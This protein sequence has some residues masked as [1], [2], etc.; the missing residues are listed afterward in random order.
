MKANMLDGLYPDNPTKEALTLL[1]DHYAAL[2]TELDRLDPP[3]G[4]ATWHDRNIDLWELDA[5]IAILRA[6]GLSLEEA[7]RALVPDDQDPWADLDQER[8]LAIIACPDFGEFFRP[9]PSATP[10]TTPTR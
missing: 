2:A 5:E 9:L 3:G 8:H 1:A 6:Q 10:V 4:I 7:A